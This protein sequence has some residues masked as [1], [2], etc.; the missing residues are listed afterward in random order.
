MLNAA[1]IDNREPQHIQTIKIGDVVP[2]IQ[3]LPT[4]D[5]W[6]ACNDANLIVERKTPSDLLASIADGRLF[7]QCAAMAKASPWSYIV[8]TGWLTCQHSMVVVDGQ[9]SQWQMRSVQGALLTVQELGI[10]IVHCDGDQDYA[11]TLLWLANRKRDAIKIK[12]QRRDTVMQ[13][14]AESLLCALPGISEKRAGDLLKF[15][16]TGAWA[17]SYLT[18]N[19]NSNNV[20]GVG[21]GTRKRTRKVLGLKDNEFLAV[22]EWTNNDWK[23]KEKLSK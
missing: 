21:P 3:Q 4:G 7:E 16:G 23:E 22:L 20:P 12:A 17:L 18:D 1:L 14:P 11:A 13:S 8:V 2:M 5:T 10:E 6:L 9:V 15:C 19:D